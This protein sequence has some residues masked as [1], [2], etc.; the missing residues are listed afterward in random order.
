MLHIYV[1]YFDF[2]LFLFSIF[3]SK[4]ITLSA[5]IEGSEQRSFILGYFSILSFIFKDVIF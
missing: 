5:F 2:K 4:K 1:R 3:N